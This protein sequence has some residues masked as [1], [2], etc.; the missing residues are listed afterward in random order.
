M[1]S[2][3]ME[4]F[5]KICFNKLFTYGEKGKVSLITGPKARVAFGADLIGNRPQWVRKNLIF[6]PPQDEGPRGT[7]WVR[8]EIETKN[9]PEGDGR[10]QGIL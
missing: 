8:G 10:F 3:K 5:Y 9:G 1:V 7:T 2:Y 6:I 4:N